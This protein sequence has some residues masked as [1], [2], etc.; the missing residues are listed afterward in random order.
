MNDE[1]ESRE[2]GTCSKYG[3]LAEWGG[4]S[5]GVPRAVEKSHLKR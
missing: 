5:G 3:T 1:E 2:L 4:F